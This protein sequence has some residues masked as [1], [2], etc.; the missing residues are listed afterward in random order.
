[1]TF[2]KLAQR[3]LMHDNIPGEHKK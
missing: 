1:M 3:T 2:V